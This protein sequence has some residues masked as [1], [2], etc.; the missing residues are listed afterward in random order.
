MCWTLCF[1]FFIELRFS[2]GALSYT[3]LGHGDL[4]LLLEI[5]KLPLLDG[6]P[7]LSLCMFCSESLAISCII[8]AI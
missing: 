6:V 4:K 7:V 2:V 5:R 8:F 3:S 1:F